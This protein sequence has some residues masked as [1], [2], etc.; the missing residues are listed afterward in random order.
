MKFKRNITIT[1]ACFLSESMICLI[2][3]LLIFFL[4]FAPKKY[5]EFILGIFLGIPII[6]MILNVFLYLLSLIFKMFQRLTI[7][8]NHNH[9]IV[10]NKNSS[11]TIY[12]KDIKGISYDLGSMPSRTNTQSSELV[13][14]G[15]NYSTLVSIKNPSLIM[16]HLIKKKCKH[17]KVSYYNSKRFLYEFLISLGV[18]LLILALNLSGI[19]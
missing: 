18:T 10:K 3:M 5:N 4:V 7:T 13:L 14:F 1:L 19:I 8:I 6:I 17:I 11:K 12:Y 15:E 9:M 16:T 2:P